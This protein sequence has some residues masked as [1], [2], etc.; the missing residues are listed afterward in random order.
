MQFKHPGRVK[1]NNACQM[2]DW[3]DKYYQQC[4]IDGYI[5]HQFTQMPFQKHP[6]TYVC[7]I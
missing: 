3:A 1:Q 4:S 7:L 2:A 5:D 6:E